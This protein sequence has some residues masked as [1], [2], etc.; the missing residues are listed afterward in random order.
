MPLQCFYEAL[1]EDFKL[2]AKQVVSNAKILCNT[3]QEEGFRIISGGTEN[4]LMLVDVKSKLGIT[5]KDAEIALDKI[6]ITVNKNTIPND[7]ESASLTSG[8]RLGTP[9]M[10]TRGFKEEDFIKVGQIISKCLSN[11]DDENIQSDL[12]K[13]VLELTKNR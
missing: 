7:T 1:Q 4:H 6:N 8:I 13:E 3:L 12:R 2:Y 5:G 10:T 9:A 11:I